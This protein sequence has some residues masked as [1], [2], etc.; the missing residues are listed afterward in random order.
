MSM[1]MRTYEKIMSISADQNS[2]SEHPENI[3]GR[4]VISQPN[5][6]S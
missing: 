3:G 2:E 1:I 4:Q 6:C 5:Q